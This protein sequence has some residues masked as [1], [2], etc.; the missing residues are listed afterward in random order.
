MKL[1][2]RITLR[3]SVALLLLFAVWGTVFYFVIIDEINDETDDS[4]EDYSEYII[5]RALMGEKLP[6]ADNGTNNSYFITEVDAAY[7]TANPSVRFLEEEVYIQAKK[8][9]EPARILKTIFKDR[10]SLY[11]ELTVMIP[12]IEKKDLKETILVWIVV[13]YIGLLLSILI[14][15]A[16]VIRRNLRPLYSLLDWLDNFRLDRELPVLDM[17]TG[18]TEFRK[19]GDSLVESGRR[20]V[21]AYGQQRLFIGH[22]SHELQTPIAVAVNRLELLADDPCLTE[23]QLEQ[24]LKTRQALGD[25]ARLNKTLLL[26]TKIENRQF[27]DSDEVDAGAMLHSLTDDFMEAYAHMNIRL[28]RIEKA[29]LNVLMDRTLASVLFSNLI[30]NAFI[31]NREDGQVSVEIGTNCVTVSNTAHSGALNSEY[32]FRR[33]YQGKKKEGTAG[34]GL[35]LVE[36]I[37]K[38]Y[39]ITISYLYEDG[40]H[41]FGAK[42]PASMIIFR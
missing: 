26:L 42:F 16:I 1:L 28:D 41:V 4:L 15:N 31:H 40:K 10:D 12:A 24:V 5:T 18:I 37:A 7:A 20:N 30:K 27:A 13:L 17:K 39:G 9:T 19:L 3:V 33:F 21:E 35:S 6:E 25:L 22:A 32:I 34:L 23:Q 29:A 2:Y 8:E 11:H 38:L 36:S 14:V